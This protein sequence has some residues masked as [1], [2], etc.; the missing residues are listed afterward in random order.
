MLSGG[1][2]ML[3]TACLA[4]RWLQRADGSSSGSGRCPSAIAPRT[5]DAL[6]GMPLLR[7]KPYC[8]EWNLCPST[9]MKDCNS[10]GWSA[11]PEPAHCQWMISK[12]NHL[13][14]HGLCH[15]LSEMWLL[16]PP[17]QINSNL[18]SNFC[19]LLNKDNVA[20]YKILHPSKLYI[21]LARK[22]VFFNHVGMYFRL[23]NSV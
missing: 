12:S 21:T 3:C 18:I 22:R 4:L 14:D 13:V 6:S 11:S 7:N 23:P 2:K 19:C 15:L 5:L 8:V 10:W 1:L 20:P 17:A 9:H 16:L